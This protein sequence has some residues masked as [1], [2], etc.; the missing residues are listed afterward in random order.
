MTGHDCWQ[1]SID[2]ALSLGIYGLPDWETLN[3]TERIWWDERALEQDLR[4]R[5]L[6]ARL[7]DLEER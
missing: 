5:D 1:I 6:P 4:D 3:A 2:I 7:Q